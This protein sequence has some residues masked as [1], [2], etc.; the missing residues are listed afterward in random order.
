MATPQFCA[1]K[2]EYLV[3]S[4]GNLIWNQ[5]QCAES[6]L[7]AHWL[8]LGLQK[9]LFR[10]PKDSH[11]CAQNWILGFC[12]NVNGAILKI[13]CTEFFVLFD[14]HTMKL[15]SRPFTQTLASFCQHTYDAFYKTWNLIVN[16]WPTIMKPQVFKLL[17]AWRPELIFGSSLFFRNWSSFSAIPH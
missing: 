1:E 6:L 5:I 9:T 15:Q 13:D 10:T 16:S 14:R 17:W 4:L 12:Q 2:G 3:F 11:P 7:L 8:C